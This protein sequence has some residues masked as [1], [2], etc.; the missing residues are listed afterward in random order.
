MG[1][2]LNL[3]GK[4]AGLISRFFGVRLLQPLYGYLNLFSLLG[5]NVGSATYA[6]E[7][8]GE[9]RVMR[10]IRDYF[11]KKQEPVVIFDVG[12]HRGDYAEDL[13]RIFGEDTE[14]YCFEPFNSHFAFLQERLAKYPNFKAF[15][16]ALSD[17][18][19]VTNL[20]DD[21]HS[22]PTM[23]PE[24]FH[25]VG[26]Q[27]MSVETIQTAR[28]DQFCKDHQVEHIHFLKLDIEGYELKVLQGAKE[29]IDSGNI[30]FVQFEF[31]P[32]S[33]A[34]RSFIHDFYQVFAP[35]YNLYRILR[36]GLFPLGAYHP[37]HEIFLS[38]TNYLSVRKSIDL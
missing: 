4:I 38:V 10:M 14:V 35:N 30:D 34:S 13:A 28:M 33:I 22:I 12:A 26:G 7:E 29:M 31:G 3:N 20:Y 25:I 15:K 37:K 6:F 2:T 32:P 27:P 36:N 16:L 23:V 8:N 18:E 5:M 1:T 11:S 9:I 21:E 17:K 24:V 19:E